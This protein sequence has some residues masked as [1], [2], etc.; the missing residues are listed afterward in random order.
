MNLI[1]TLRKALTTYALQNDA[2]MLVPLA[3]AAVAKRIEARRD[4]RAAAD[5]AVEFARLEKKQEDDHNAGL[6]EKASY[7]A[8]KEKQ[9]ESKIIG[10]DDLEDDINSLCC[11]QMNFEHEQRGQ[12]VS[13]RAGCTVR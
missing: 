9:P 6:D 4:E 7:K 10:L 11:H 13:T 5:A 1:P 8:L 3:D 12:D 2:L